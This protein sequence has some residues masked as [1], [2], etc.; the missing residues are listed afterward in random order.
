MVRQRNI[1]KGLP[2]PN[3]E[4]PG[5]SEHLTLEADDGI[6]SAIGVVSDSTAEVDD[7]AV[8]SEASSH[9]FIKST[10]SLGSV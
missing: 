9:E 5:S 8:T 3:S 7:E 10:F 6:D 2:F 4:G 1:K